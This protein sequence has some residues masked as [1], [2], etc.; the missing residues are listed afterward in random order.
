M[1]TATILSLA[2]TGTLTAPL[3]AGVTVTQ[4]KSF[5]HIRATAVA[6]ALKGTLFA[7]ASEDNMV[8]IM[9]SKTMKTVFQ[10]KGHPRT[11]KAVGF[12][13][14]GRYLLTG[15]ESARIWLWD[16]K[17]GKKIRE[18]PRDRGHTRGIQSF[19]FTKDG[20]RFASVGGDDVIKIWNLSGGHP[21]FTIKGNG[22]N[23]Y[24]AAF[25]P[26]GAL[27]TGT[28]AEGMRMY[29]PKKF[30]LAAK[31][32]VGGGQGANGIAVN[33]AGT[34][35]V[36]AGRDGRNIVWNLKTRKQV[37]SIKAHNDWVYNVA[38]SPNGR[39]AVSSSADTKVVVWDV[40]TFKKLATISGRSFVDSVV[41]I[42][43]DGKYI[44]STD[45][46]NVLQMHKLSP[47]QS[48]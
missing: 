2:M 27:V 4:V 26:S 32:S 35:A 20:K 29:E 24:G 39:V 8:R 22:A 48:K 18:F 17:T 38:F 12:S 23:F 43:G 21:K 47:A 10:L 9:D 40:K 6:T 28:L 13:P 15:D 30:A 16:V 45:S 14:N 31:M 46:G 37:G 36:T 1:L 5:G 44:L 19:A 42:T 33:R 7:V 11:P 25:L 3:E 34:F 41:A